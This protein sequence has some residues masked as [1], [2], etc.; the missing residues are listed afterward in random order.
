MRKR[1]PWAALETDRTRITKATPATRMRVR[2]PGGWV[3]VVTKRWN[4]MDPRRRARALAQAQIAI[5]ERTDREV[6]ARARAMVAN[7]TKT[8]TRTPRMGGA[9][10][11]V[12]AAVDTMALPGTSPLALV[13]AALA[14]VEAELTLA[15]LNRDADTAHAAVR[16]VIR[17][18]TS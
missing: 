11:T 15:V 1:V 2:V 8:V 16:R 5:M 17:S 18:L 6:R 13:R 7:R 12:R 4:A 14:P 9:T 10:V 3:V